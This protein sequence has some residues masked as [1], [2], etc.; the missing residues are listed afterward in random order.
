MAPVSD[1]WRPYLTRGA[2][3]ADTWPLFV[4]RGRYVHHGVIPTNTLD[5]SD[6]GYKLRQSAVETCTEKLPQIRDLGAVQVGVRHKPLLFFARLGGAPEGNPSTQTSSAHSTGG[7]THAAGGHALPPASPQSAVLTNFLLEAILSVCPSAVD[8][9][10]HAVVWGDPTRLTQVD[11][12]PPAC[13]YLLPTFAQDPSHHPLAPTFFPPSPKA[14][15]P[16]SSSHLLLRPSPTFSFLGDDQPTHMHV[17]TSLRP[18]PHTQELHTSRAALT[19]DHLTMALQQALTV[20]ARERTA[21]SLECVK[22]LLC[23]S[24]PP[25]SALPEPPNLAF[26]PRC[27]HCSPRAT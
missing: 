1:T 3:L 19:N 9:V 21:E 20:A 12:R 23:A 25:A 16:T 8:A 11:A 4:T 6:K 15:P 22:I 13:P 5:P 14:P 27:P 18:F 26:A 7:P 17:D 10:M 2:R 24:A